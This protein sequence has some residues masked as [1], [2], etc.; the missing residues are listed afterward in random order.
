M[1]NITEFIEQLESGKHH[2]SI[3]AYSSKGHYCRFGPQS[4][5]WH[6]PQLLKAIEQHLQVIVEMHND[7]IDDAFLLL[8]E[9]HMAI[10]VNFHD[11]HI[12]SIDMTQAA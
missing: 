11:G 10:P 8:P 4:N 3:W 9:V 12:S 5:K 6:T 1:R 7:E 2:F